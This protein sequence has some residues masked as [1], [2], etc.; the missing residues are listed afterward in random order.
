MKKLF[1]ALFFVSLLTFIPVGRAEELAVDTA[2]STVGFSIPILGGLS[3]VRGKFAD[4][5][6][7]INYDEKDVTKSSVNAVIKTASIDT[8]IAARDNHLKTADF[9]DAE[10]YPEITFQS[11]RVE[12]KGKGLVAYGTFTMHGVSKEI[13]LPITITGKLVDPATKQTSYGF[14]SMLKINRMDYG[15]NYQRKGAENFLGNE[16]T[17]ELFLLSRPPQPK[18][19]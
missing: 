14:S 12:K 19:S 2:H 5:N 18:K 4:F 3:Q 7:T 10:K 6:A 16:V 8:G 15:I 1:A 17:I 9:F 11:S 13:M